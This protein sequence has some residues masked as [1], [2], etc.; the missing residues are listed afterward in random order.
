MKRVLST[1]LA[2]VLLLLL[3]P[4]G[5]ITAYAAEFEYQYVAVDGGV[6]ITGYTGTPS[7]ALVIPSTLDGQ[8]VVGIGA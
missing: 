5:A 6:Q 1:L 3:I 2:M 4:A 7:G 8:P